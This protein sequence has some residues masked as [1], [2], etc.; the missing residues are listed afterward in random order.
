MLGRKGWFAQGKV[1]IILGPL[2]KSQL[3]K[4]SPGTTTLKALN[5]I[6]R[7]YIGIEHEYDF[8]MR[9]KKKDIPERV[10]LSSKE[11]AIIGWNTWLSNDTGQFIDSDET[12]D[13]PVSSRRFI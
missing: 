12:I 6:V 5:E 13:I 11:S 4:F 3:H 1:N 10:N 9:I 7:L 2:N 8:I